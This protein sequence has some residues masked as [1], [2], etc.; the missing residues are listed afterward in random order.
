MTKHLLALMIS[1]VLGWVGWWLGGF[2]HIA[3]ALILGTVASLYGF[4]LG[5][6]LNAYY[7]E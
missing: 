4:Y 3:A 5:R 1:T 2:I 7:L 6:K